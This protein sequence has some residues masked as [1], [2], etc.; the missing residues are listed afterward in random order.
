MPRE[1]QVTEESVMVIIFSLMIFAG[2]A[3]LWIAM[4]NRRAV[5]EMEHRERLAMIQSG[6][7]PAPEADPLAFEAHM[8]SS[9]PA[10]SRQ[11]R[12]RTA[13]TLTIG[14][15]MALLMLL[16]F[17]GVEDIAIG[18]GGAFA[19]LGASFLL[20]GLLMSPESKAP[21]PLIRRPQAPPPDTP[22]SSASPF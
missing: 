9:S 16:W 20:N 2:V 10:M 5:R 6:V 4:S 19:V 3:V 15:G 8:E 13:G 11:D 1:A 7:M 21:R 17:S 18:V 12:W 22:S 14:F